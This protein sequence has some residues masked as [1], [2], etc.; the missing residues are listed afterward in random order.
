[1]ITRREV[2]TFVLTVMQ[3]AFLNLRE[4]GGRA[5]QTIL[6]EMQ[7]AMQLL[8]DAITNQTPLLVLRDFFRKFQGNEPVQPALWR[9]LE[10]LTESELSLVSSGGQLISFACAQEVEMRR[11]RRRDEDLARR[12]AMAEG[13]LPPSPSHRLLVE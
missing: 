3:R 6:C 9:Y 2:D 7:Q 5:D 13:P 10:G 4:C 12:K 11:I 8:P 1:M